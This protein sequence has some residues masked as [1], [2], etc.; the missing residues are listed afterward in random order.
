MKKPTKQ[1]FWSRAKAAA[2]ALRGYSAVT[3]TRYRGR[4]GNDPIRSEEIELSGYDRDRL[5]SAALE[6]RRNNPVVASISR[7]RKA[8]I[9][10]RGIFPQASTGDNDLDEQIDKSWQ[11]Y[12][13]EPEI[14]GQMDMREIQQQMIDSILFYGDCGLVFTNQDGKIQ[15]VDGTRI[16]NKL[17][18]STASEESPYQNGVKVDQFGRVQEYLVGNRVYGVVRDQK[19]I[20]AANFIPFFRRIRPIQYRGIPEI[21]PILNVLQDCD[22]YDNIEMITAKVAAS[23]SVA[24]TRENA[25]EF[26]VANRESGT[27]QDEDGN[28]ERFEP[29]RFHYMNPGESIQT[30]SA[31]G[32][33]NVDGVQW[34]AYLLRKAGAAVGIPLEFLLMEIGGSSFSA[35]QGVVLQYQQSVESYQT[36][37]IRAMDRWYRRWLIRE[38]AQGRI[39]VPAGVEIF[40]ARWQRPAFRWINR[41]A[42]VSADEKYLRM[43]AMSLDDVTSVF[44]YTA[45]DVLIRKAQNIETAKRV[46]ELHGIDDWRD[47]M[48]QYPTNLSANLQDINADGNDIRT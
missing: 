5:I 9:V 7:L 27:D 1:S 36:D 28:L 32:R 33:P 48:N 34:V 40:R 6:L 24:V 14:T 19:P 45:E 41:I 3:N 12:A 21:A 2:Y 18:G 22:E 44:G 25:Y 20:P 35:S 47:L 26:E 38:I 31:N 17:G 30:I 39:R 11:E 13:R 23:L 4:R 10:G 29:G 15:F 8:D 37:M 46:A 42:Q 16:A 43:G